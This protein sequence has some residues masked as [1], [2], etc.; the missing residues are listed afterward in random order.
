MNNILVIRYFI[1]RILIKII[2][3]FNKNGGALGATI[4][5]KRRGN[6]LYLILEKFYPKSSLI[7]EN[8]F[9]LGLS[10]SVWNW[11][12]NFSLRFIPIQ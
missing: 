4:F 2:K 11:S 6:I 9:F 3:I 12:K 7:V 8:Y 1:S 10:Q 5:H